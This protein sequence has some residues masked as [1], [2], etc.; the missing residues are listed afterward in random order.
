[1]LSVI[2]INDVITVTHLHF[3][4]FHI[5]AGYDFERKRVSKKIPPGAYMHVTGEDGRR[6]YMALKTCTAMEKE[7]IGGI[8]SWNLLPFA[9][10]RG[11]RWNNVM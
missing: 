1:M 2:L 8:M 11:N 5:I 6:A 10:K 4:A 7:V 9:V 3:V